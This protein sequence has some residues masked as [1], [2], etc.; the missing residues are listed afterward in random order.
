MVEFTRNY[1]GENTPDID[2]GRWPAPVRLVIACCTAV[3]QFL[4]GRMA[5]DGGAWAKPRRE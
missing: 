3:T 5:E 4:G 2:E 1:G